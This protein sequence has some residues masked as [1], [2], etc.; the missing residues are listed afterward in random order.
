MLSNLASNP[1]SIDWQD[2]T[3]TDQLHRDRYC[4]V[5]SLA[6]RD[7]FR[8]INQHAW[9]YGPSAN[10][11]V[12]RIETLARPLQNSPLD[13]ESL[14]D[15]LQRADSGDI[16]AGRAVASFFE[17]WNQRRDARPGF[18]AFYDEVKEEADSADWPHLLRDRLGLGHYGRAGG[19]P[20]PVALMR[21]S[22]AEVFSA[23]EHRKLPTACAVPTVLDGGMHEFFFPVP[24]EHSY[25]LPYTWCRIRQVI[26]PPRYS[27]A[28]STTDVNT[29]G[30]WVGSHVRIE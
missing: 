27:I 1:D 11:S 14:D 9:L 12:V 18:A 20:L 16:D 26:L 7:A 23:Q 3:A 5:A 4:A 13:I 30:G 19:S 25:G 6:V 22:L 8:E 15:L 21:Y 24:R 2:W 10:Q 17:Q 29:C 28:G